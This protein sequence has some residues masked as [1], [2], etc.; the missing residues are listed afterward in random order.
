M[1]AVRVTS[2]RHARLLAQLSTAEKAA[3]VRVKRQQCKPEAIQ[4]PDMAA[5]FVN[6]HVA[7]DGSP[8]RRMIGYAAAF[9]H[10]LEMLKKGEGTEVI[11]G[12]ASPDERSKASDPALGEC[13]PLLC[14]QH[15]AVPAPDANEMGQPEVL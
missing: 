13:P 3:R 12:G 15:R 1:P 10:L 8:E 9:I 7:W 6:L 11:D 2:V 4:G 14:R 5:Y